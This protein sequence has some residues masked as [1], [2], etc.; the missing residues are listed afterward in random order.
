ME[1]Y[2][3]IM[4]GILLLVL[5][6]AGNFVAETLGCKTQKLLSENMFVKQTIIFIIVY[7]VINFTNSDDSVHPLKILKTTLSIYILFILFTKMNVQF[8]LIVFS[9]LI[10]SYVISIFI[11][12]YKKITPEDKKKI[13]LLKKIQNMLYILMISFILIGFGLYYNKQSM[14][15][16]KDWSAFKFIFGVNKCAS[17]K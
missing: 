9:L 16:K 17:L 13:N 1:D 8:T 2:D 4:K 10:I 3:D 11:D 14:E 12:Y 7:F 5:A 6:V 15:H